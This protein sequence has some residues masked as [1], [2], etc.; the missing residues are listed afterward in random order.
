MKY[1]QFKRASNRADS[2]AN[3]LTHYFSQ[4][5]AVPVAFLC[6][7]IG[8]SPN[9]VT[10]LFLVVGILS[11]IAF[12]FQQGILAYIFWRIHLIFDMADGGLARA[13]KT[14]S[15]N[16]VG[17]DRSNHIVINTTVL[18]GAVASTENIILANFL[19]VSFFLHYFFYRNYIRDK[20][21]TQYFSLPKSF[22]RH[23]IGIEGFIAISAVLITFSLLDLIHWVAITYSISFIFLFFFKLHHHL[24]S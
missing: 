24:N 5:F 15:P 19:L 21:N 3:N 20:V 13:T 16:A 10:G 1:S 18:L 23:L 8:L 14:F 9:H 11:G 12:Y 7:R 17:F 4:Y 2:S 22:I 6:Y